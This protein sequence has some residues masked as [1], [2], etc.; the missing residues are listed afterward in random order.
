MKYLA[1]LLVAGMAL[2]SVQVSAGD[3]TADATTDLLQRL[4]GL[5]PA[6]RF[7]SVTTTPVSGLFEVVMGRNMAFT[8][9]TGRHFV[10]GHLFDMQTQSDL[11]AERKAALSRIDFSTLPLQNSIKYVQGKGQRTLAVFS[12]PDCP[13][14]KRVEAELAKLDNATIHVFP[15][16]IQSLHPDA[17]ARSAAIWCAPD[18][19]QAW[20][21]VMTGGAVPKMATRDECIVPIAANVALAERLGIH[22]TP[23]LL[24]LDGRLL[25]GAATAEK[26][27]AWLNAGQ[28]K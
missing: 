27:S 8:D 24:A 17:A 20:R 18:R 14:C 21:Q 6:T 2:S 11:T 28:D 15:Y 25:P 9:A 10:F 22:G 1:K 13:Y 4:R 5:Y 23:T 16:P 19:A 3:V 26:I 12:D 7:T